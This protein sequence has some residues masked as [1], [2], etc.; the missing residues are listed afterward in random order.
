MLHIVCVTEKEKRKKK[1][2]KVSVREKGR[3]ERLKEEIGAYQ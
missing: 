1:T 2:M 3:G